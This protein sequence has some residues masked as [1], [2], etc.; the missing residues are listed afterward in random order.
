MKTKVKGSA[1]AS[2]PVQL[3]LPRDLYEAMRVQAA[4]ELLPVAAWIRRACDAD[5]KRKKQQAA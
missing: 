2:A 3:R 4:S 1:P 5:L